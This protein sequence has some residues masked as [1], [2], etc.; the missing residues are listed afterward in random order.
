MAPHIKKGTA[1]K[2]PITTVD[3]EIII[4]MV[5]IINNNIIQKI[6]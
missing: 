4:T 3:I 1:D 5:K 2:D 6:I